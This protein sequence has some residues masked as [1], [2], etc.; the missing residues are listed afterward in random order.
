M[1][2]TRP[3]ETRTVCVTGASS[4]IGRAFADLLA[5]KG[6][7]LIVVARREAELASLKSELEAA[8]QVSVQT[9]AADLGQQA[10]LDAVI[11][12]AKEAGYRAAFTALNGV[13]R[14]GDHLF[15]LPRLAIS[16]RRSAVDAYELMGVS[17]AVD[18]LLHVVTGSQD[19][20]IADLEG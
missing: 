19:R 10:G 15:A 12:A 7:D 14:P 8:H 11:A 3:I 16:G 20:L 5:K 4:G 1:T 18:E 13:C 17:G 9:I 2:S 6:H